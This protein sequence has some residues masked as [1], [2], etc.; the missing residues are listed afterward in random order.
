MSSLFKD[1]A[2][3]IIKRIPKVIIVLL[4]MATVFFNQ[5]YAGVISLTPATYSTSGLYSATTGGTFVSTIAAGF[6]SSTG[7]TTWTIT[8]YNIRHGQSWAKFT[9]NVSPG[10]GTYDLYIYSQSQSVLYSK[11]SLTTNISVDLSAIKAL[12]DGAPFFV[13]IILQ[14]L[15]TINSITATYVG[16]QLVCY[17]SPF[18]ITSGPMKI[19]FDVN[20]SSKVTLEVFDN[21][22]RL[23]K[24]ILTD[25]SISALA[26][27]F[28]HV[29][30]W[31]GKDDNGRTIN[32]GLYTVVVRVN[33][34]DT[35]NTT[36]KY[37]STFRVLVV[38]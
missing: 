25:K 34:I 22:G 19:V 16:N 21:R 17:P 5:L 31:D 33:P 6:S 9:V 27:R 35:S 37:I 18:Q 24:T 7:T 3:L 2:N 36:D 8:G 29:L 26:S 28:D 32:T 30:T 11:T 4:L 15:I 1:F 12:N 20:A 23:V 14:P 10:G 38:R 13:K